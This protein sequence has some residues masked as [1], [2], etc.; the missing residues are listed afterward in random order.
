MTPETQREAISVLGELCGLAPE[1][2][3]G[4]LLSHLSFLG[5][6][7]IGRGLAD[8]EDDE[9]IAIMY[10]HRAELRARLK[11]VADPVLP[12]LSDQTS[13]SGS[14]ILTTEQR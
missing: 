11:G 4:Q 14:S 13:V 8:L 3:L 2:R 5:E 1:I 9:L 6:S 7:H 10:R 12:P